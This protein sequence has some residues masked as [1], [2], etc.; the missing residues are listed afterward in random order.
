MKNVEFKCDRCGDV[1]DECEEHVPHIRLTNPPYAVE[2][3]NWTHT[4]LLSDYDLCDKCM[5]VIVL[6][7]LHENYVGD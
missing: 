6:T 3:K 1:I 4:N 5:R 2:Y 7:L